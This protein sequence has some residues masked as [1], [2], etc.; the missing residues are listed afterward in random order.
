MERSDDQVLQ[1]PNSMTT[2]PS[3][4]H[5][6]NFHEDDNNG[7]VERWI[8]DTRV[9]AAARDNPNLV[10]D[11]R[12]RDLVLPF[13]ALGNTRMNDTSNNLVLV[14][15]VVVTVLLPVAFETLRLGCLGEPPAL[16]VLT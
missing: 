2:Y 11:D 13:T 7:Y 14:V 15:D 10:I 9:A 6:T 4:G 1:Q 12:P 5:K 8:F 3:R 16:H